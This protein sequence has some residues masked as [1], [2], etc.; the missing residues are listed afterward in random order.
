MSAP[1][2]CWTWQK[3]K[4]STAQANDNGPHLLAKVKLV[5]NDGIDVFPAHDRGLSSFLDGKSYNELHPEHPGTCTCDSATPWPGDYI[6]STERKL[7]RPSKSP[8]LK[9]G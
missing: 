7:R 9:S 8:A 3:N 4:V 5:V 1:T 2:R 6:R